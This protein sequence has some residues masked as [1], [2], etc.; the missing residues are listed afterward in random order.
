MHLLHYICT[1]TNNPFV[2][3]QIIIPAH[4]EEQYLTQTLE[5]LVSQTLL[6]QKIIIVNDNSTDNTQAIAKKFEQQYGFITTLNTQSG[7]SH[8]PG[9]KVINAF[10][11]GY[12]LLSNDVEFICKFDADLI[13]PSNY[14]ETVV[15]LFRTHPKVGIASG[16]LHVKKGQSWVYEN[17]A[18]KNHVRGPIKMYRKSCF[19]DIGGLKKSI[20]WDTVD[21]LLAQYH[22]WKILTDTNLI[23]KHLK[24]TGK[25]Y[26]KTSKYMQGEAL[27]KMRYGFLITLIAASKMAFQKKDASLVLSYLKGYLKAKKQALPYLVSK[28]EGQFIRKLRWRTIKNKIKS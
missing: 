5:S 3:I 16:I 23:V 19:T 18:D 13:F 6:P 9:S 15:S 22:D 1:Q 28:N 26:H 2:N 25:T 24:P 11:K 10:Y 7:T 21:V 27:Y 4:N 12:Q 17:I 8:L 14:L 20:G